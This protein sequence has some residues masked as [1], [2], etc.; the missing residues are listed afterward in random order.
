MR[1][2]IAAYLAAHYAPGSA[3]SRSTIIRRIRSGELRGVKDGQWYVLVGSA[4]P[5]PRIS[6]LARQ[7]VL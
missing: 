4:R 7:F 2:T 6:E 3:P 5:D 1:Q